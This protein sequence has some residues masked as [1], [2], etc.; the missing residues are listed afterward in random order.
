M[1][2]ATRKNKFTVSLKSRSHSLIS[3][4]GETSG[5]DDL[6]M[7]PHEIL[8]ASLA[9]CTSIT[10]QMYAARKS[11]ALESCDVLVSIASENAEGTVFSV[12]VN[13][14]GN[15]DVGQI[16]RLLEIATKCPVH[17]IL[18]GP[19]KINMI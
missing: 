10:V 19:I 4:V 6:G 8:E 5:G 9:A 1:I 2:Q 18:S 3:D 15:L 17:K 14:V 7:T 13:L 11:W 16:Q 12:K